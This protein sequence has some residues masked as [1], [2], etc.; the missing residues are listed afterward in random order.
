MELS[1]REGRCSGARAG[2]G[3]RN[4]SCALREDPWGG[5][6]SLGLL[7]SGCH[8]GQH[9]PCSDLEEN[10]RE[11]EEELVGTGRPQHGS[12]EAEPT[13]VQGGGG[14]PERASWP[15]VTETYRRS[16]T[17]DRKERT[18]TMDLGSRA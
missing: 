8:H 15:N 1:L 7:P 11:P 12:W 2:R 16:K 6:P 13:S 3:P 17:G 18:E 5:N 10:L 4:P 14:P 9:K